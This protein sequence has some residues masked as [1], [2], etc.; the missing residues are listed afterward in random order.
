[1][2]RNV[3]PGAVERITNMIGTS[4]QHSVRNFIS[5]SAEMMDMPL[6]DEYS[7]ESYTVHDD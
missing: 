2:P 3:V 7:H 1:M 4:E 5:M 6:I